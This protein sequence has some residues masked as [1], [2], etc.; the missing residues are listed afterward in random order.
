MSALQVETWN[1][2]SL[3]KKVKIIASGTLDLK[4]QQASI[5]ATIVLPPLG[6]MSRR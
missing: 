6:I 5:D 3:L 1:S 4:K 2:Y